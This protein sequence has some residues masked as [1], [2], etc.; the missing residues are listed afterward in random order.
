MI[1]R[2][3][4]RD[5]TLALLLKLSLLFLLWFLFFSHAPKSL[6]PQQVTYHFFQTSEQPHDA[7]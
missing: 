4:T 5:I 3:P 6:S 1:K 2:G 7:P